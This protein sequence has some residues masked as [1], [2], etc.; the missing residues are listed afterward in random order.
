MASVKWRSIGLEKRNFI[1]F[2]GYRQFFK[3]FHHDFTG[4]WFMGY[5]KE[6]N[7]LKTSR[8]NTLPRIRG[9]CFIFTASSLKCSS[10]NDAYLVIYPLS[11]FFLPF[12][13]F[14]S[15]LGRLF[16]LQGFWFPSR[17]VLFLEL[18]WNAIQSEAGRPDM[19]LRLWSRLKG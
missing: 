10:C 2:K 12:L 6:K 5:K 17:S 11:K 16:L 3:G 7:P 4:C 9:N 13:D 8:H 1:S 19:R 18:L 15:L 14:L